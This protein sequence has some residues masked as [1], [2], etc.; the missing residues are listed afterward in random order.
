MALDRDRRQPARLADQPQ[1]P[2]ARRA[3]RAVVERE[4]AEHGAGGVEHGDRPAGAQAVLAREQ[5]KLPPAGVVLDVG[6]DH[7]PGVVGGGAAGADLG[8]DGAAVDPLDVAAR[9]ARGGA[10]AERPRLAVEQQDAPGHAVGVALDPAHEPRQDLLQRRLGE[11]QLMDLV[12]GG[13]QVVGAAE[14]E[15]LPAVLISQAS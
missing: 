4:G 2:G 15:Q 6:D 12:V 10:V 14:V 1:L 5:A 11:H 3:R 13:Q 8:A 7:L 9:E